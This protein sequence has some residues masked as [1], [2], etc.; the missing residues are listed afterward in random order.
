MTPWQWW[1]ETDFGDGDGFGQYNVGPEP[2]R[3]AII[4]AALRESVPGELFIIVEA[5]ESEDMRY[6][7][8]DFIPF[9]R[10]R[11]KEMLVNGPHLIG[12]GA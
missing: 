5:R 8:E 7:G 4:A 9:L 1:A 2:S 11:N 12:E 10:T 6:E 3:E